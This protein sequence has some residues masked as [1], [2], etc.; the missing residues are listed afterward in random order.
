[1]GYY[2][3]E[4]YFGLG[5]LLLVVFQALNLVLTKIKAHR[6]IVSTF[7]LLR[8]LQ[9]TKP[10]EFVAFAS[11]V[12]GLR[13]SPPHGKD[14]FFLC[15]TLLR[16]WN[17]YDTPKCTWNRKRYFRFIN[18]KTSSSHIHFSLFLTKGAF[19]RVPIFYTNVLDSDFLQ[20]YFFN[21]LESIQ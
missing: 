14:N 9:D 1:M 5:P 19:S 16:S 17:N 13:Q 2:V 6:H 15:S 21:N 18:Q 8:I 12:S 4:K 3:V 7:F 20:K 10:L 11:P